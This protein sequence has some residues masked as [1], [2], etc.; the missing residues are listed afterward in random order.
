M[1]IFVLGIRKKMSEY[2]PNYLKTI[3]QSLERQL[4]KQNYAKSITEDSEFYELREI[5]KAKQIDLKKG[6]GNGP[7]RAD[8]IDD[9]EV[10]ILYQKEQLGSTSPDT[11]WW[12]FTHL[13]WNGGKRGAL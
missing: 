1:I 12:Q 9:E 4:R 2:E 11:L 6:K 10:E 7:K 5:L 13:F 8:P 3:Q